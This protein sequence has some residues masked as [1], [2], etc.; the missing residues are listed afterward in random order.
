MAKNTLAFTLSL[1]ETPVCLYQSSSIITILVHRM[2]LLSRACG[3][4]GAQTAKTLTVLWL[5]R[6]EKTPYVV[7]ERTDYNSRMGS[8]NWIKE[9]NLWRKGGGASKKCSLKGYSHRV[10]KQWLIMLVMLG[11]SCAECAMFRE[12]RSARFFTALVIAAARSAWHT[13][14]KQNVVIW[15]GRL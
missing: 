9:R 5:L 11:N 7:R 3:I 2:V 4:Q 8:E 15:E 6:P 14:K 13:Q 1:I 12:C 10:P